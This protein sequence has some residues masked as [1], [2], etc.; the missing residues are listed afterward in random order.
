MTPR[1]ATPRLV[2]SVGNHVLPLRTRGLSLEGT[3]MTAS[4]QALGQQVDVN[5]ASLYVEDHGQGDPLVLVHAGL[6]SSGS[7]AGVVPLLAESFRVITFDN[8]GHGRSTNPSGVLSFEQL[9][10]DTATLVEA[11]GLE[12]PFVGGWSDGGEVALQFGLRH[13]GRARALV[14]GGTSL[15]LGSDAFRTEVRSFLHVSDDGEVDIG[16]VAG[17]VKET[18]LPMLRQSHPQGEQH[19]QTVV[20][21][22]ATMWL[23]YA[24][25]TREEVERIAEPVLVMVGDRDEHVPVEEAVRLYRSLPQAELAILPGTSHLRPLM[26][27]ATF[28]RSVTDFF[29]RH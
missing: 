12:R 1:R 19:W 9:A 27:P 14:A 7:W 6:L 23:G 5:G 16:A 26:D 24:G 11:L 28:V 13:P 8:R 22:S 25:L 20:Q 10:D 18:L 17:A 29:Q 2:L 15:E 21:Q 4:A 3:T